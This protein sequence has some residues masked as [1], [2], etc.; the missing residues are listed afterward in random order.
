MMPK[1]EGKSIIRILAIIM[2]ISGIVLGV[3]AI[4]GQ[5]LS[6]R[7]N[8]KITEEAIQIAERPIAGHSPSAAEQAAD[9][10]S[11]QTDPY[12]D[13]LF[14]VNMDELQS[15]NP[16]IIGWLCI[17]DA[18]ISYPLLQTDN[19]DYYLKHSWDG[20]TNSCGSIYMDRRSSMSDW[21]TVIYGHNMNNGSMFA[22]LRKYRDWDFAEK[23]PLLYILYGSIIKQYALAAAFEAELDDVP[24][25][26]GDMDTDAGN[27]FLERLSAKT[28]TEIEGPTASLSTCT[29]MGHQ[30]RWV[31]VFSL[32]SEVE[33]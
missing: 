24:Y 32:E 2:C 11:E 31:T 17:P 12:I 23:N 15:V 25:V 3:T 30:T 18:D 5:R 28:G 21:N 27:S 20:S 10:D 22:G 9:T 19:N 7:E 8:D 14:S 29:G 13:W 33:A 26:F 16:D 6:Y 4:I 1:K